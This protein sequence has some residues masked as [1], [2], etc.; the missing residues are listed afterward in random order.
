MKN[1][2]FNIIMPLFILPAGCNTYN[3]SY[4]LNDPRYS[5]GETLNY[6]YSNRYYVQEIQR[7]H[8]L[9][10]IDIDKPAIIEIPSPVIDSIYPDSDI[11]GE[12]I[13]CFKTDRDGRVMSYEIIKR[14]GLGLDRYVIS[15]IKEIKIKPLSH[16]GEDGSSEFGATFVFKPL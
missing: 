11:S 12:A 8:F 9:I 3:E 5:T 16:R 2:L 10:N 14:A 15:I 6:E 4:M 13:V 7:D 1:I